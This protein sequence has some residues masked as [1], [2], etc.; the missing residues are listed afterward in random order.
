MP[1]ESDHRVDFDDGIAIHQAGH[2]DQRADGWR[3]RWDELAT[4]RGKRLVSLIP[5]QHREGDVVDE[6]A[7]VPHLAPGIHHHSFDALHDVPVLR[8][9]IPLAHDL[10]LLIPGDLARDPKQS[11]PARDDAM[12]V[13]PDR[14]A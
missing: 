10:A 8:F 3:V 4:H 12:R 9:K 13:G 14:L 5:L 7:Y 1:S 2:L 6:L 11:V